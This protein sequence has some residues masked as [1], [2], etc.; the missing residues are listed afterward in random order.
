MSKVVIIHGM[1]NEYRGVEQVLAGWLPALRDGI[2]H[3]GYEPVADEQV[4]VGFYGH[5]FR[6]AGGFLSP[7]LNHRDVQ[8]QEE[9]ALLASYWDAAVAADEDVP[10]PED[11]TKSFCLK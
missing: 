10:D 9:R 3:A 6:P 8:S 2:R 5:I 11:D 7:P 4:A 1:N